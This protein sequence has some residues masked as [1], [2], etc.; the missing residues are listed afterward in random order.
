M[1]YLFQN[2]YKR[3]EGYSVSDIIISSDGSWVTAKVTDYS[4]Y[5]SGDYNNTFLKTRVF[6]H[7]DNKYLNG[8]SMPVF[9]DSRENAENTNNDDGAFV[10]HPVYGMCYAQE[11]HNEEGLYLR[12]YKMDDVLTV[13]NSGSQ[14]MPF[15]H[16]NSKNYLYTREYSYEK[17]F[18]TGWAFEKS[19]TAIETN[20]FI[21]SIIKYCETEMGKIPV[22]EPDNKLSKIELYKNINHITI[23]K[24]VNA[25]RVYLYVNKSN[26]DTNIYFIEIDFYILMYDYD[27]T[28][29]LH[30]LII[31]NPYFKFSE[32]DNAYPKSYFGDFYKL[33]EEGEPAYK[34]FLNEMD[35]HRR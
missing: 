4:E 27:D 22:S 15:N 32:S 7:I 5:N 20:Q 8:I 12:L 21:D 2:I 16:D 31:S 11:W 1:S 18:I 30:K 9:S 29:R 10:Q 33:L 19:D 34:F 17:E 26:E 14:S 25:A 35:K 3:K 13:I 6:F 28:Y 23:F 24:D